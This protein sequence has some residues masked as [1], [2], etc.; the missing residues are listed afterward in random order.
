M[1][2]NA[3]T[4]N[5]SLNWLSFEQLND[6]L[7]IKPKKTLIFFHTDW[8]S[9]CKKML[10]E[11]FVDHRV[12]KKL[13]Q[14]Y[15]IVKFDAESNETIHFD[16]VTIAKENSSARVNSFHPIVTLLTDTKQPRFPI[17]I[18]LNEDFKIEKTKYNYLSIKELLKIL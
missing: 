10:R 7:T 14:E 17:T 1:Q 9:Y 2:V 5:D 15:Y 13:Q 16:G 6:S 18:V 11:S 12:I 3:Q 4:K 8:C